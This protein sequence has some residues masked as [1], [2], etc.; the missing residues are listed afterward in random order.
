MASAELPSFFAS[1]PPSSPRLPVELLAQIVDEAA[2]DR[3]E[4]DHTILRHLCL[5]SKSILPFA[6]QALYREI[7][8]RFDDTE[9]PSDNN[10]LFTDLTDELLK[11]ECQ[12]LKIDAEALEEALDYGS[13]LA[14]L[15]VGFTVIFNNGAQG[16]VH[17]TRYLIDSILGSCPNIIS[18]CSSPC[19]HTEAEAVVDALMST[20]RNLSELELDCTSNLPKLLAHLHNLRRLHLRRPPNGS[21]FTAMKVPSFTF[22]LRSLCFEDSF[23]YIPANLSQELLRSSTSSLRYLDFDPPSKADPLQLPQL[24]ALTHLKLQSCGDVSG[25]LAQVIPRY[26]ALQVLHLDFPPSPAQLHLLPPQLP[27]VGV[28]RVYKAEKLAPLLRDSSRGALRQ[29]VVGKGGD[30]DWEELGE[31]HGWSV[32]R[33]REKVVFAR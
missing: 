33:F 14:R 17:L 7:S 19:W 30:E 28:V 1:S 18:F 21:D 31:E 26:P 16:A 5:S 11:A 9:G 2:G 22:R 23:A 6:R 10:L 13:H 8:V 3:D 4:L 20:R 24:P 32:E 29:V 15:V 12:K 27:S 25:E